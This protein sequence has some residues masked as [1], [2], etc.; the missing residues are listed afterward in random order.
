MWSL[1]PTVSFRFL[2][3]IDTDI[4][5]DAAGVL[6]SFI[7][8]TAK[9]NLRDIPDVQ[10]VMMG[11]FIRKEDALDGQRFWT[12]VLFERLN[13]DCCLLRLLIWD[14]QQSGTECLVL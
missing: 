11:C 1:E 8:S 13:V 4:A 14:W 9:Q 6:C 2:G 10:Y 3:I 7:T 12:L 5:C